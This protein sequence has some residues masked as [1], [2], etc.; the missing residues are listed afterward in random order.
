MCILHARAQP[1]HLRSIKRELANL[2]DL[3]HPNICALYGVEATPGW[4]HL[5]II[6]EA[7]LG[8]GDE[9]WPLSKALRDSGGRLAEATARSVFAQLLSGLAFAHS[10]L[11][12]HR[13]LNPEHVHVARAAAFGSDGFTVKLTNFTA[14]KTVLEPAAPTL[15]GTVAMFRA[16]EVTL[17]E[18]SPAGTELTPAQT[19]A[20]DVWAAGAILMCMLAG[21]AAIS[22]WYVSDNKA[23]DYTTLV[24]AGGSAPF[25]HRCVGRLPDASPGAREAA[26]A[27]FTET[28]EARPSAAD[29]LTKSAWVAA[30]RYVPGPMPPALLTQSKAQLHEFV[31]AVVAAAAAMA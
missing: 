1:R 25:W 17:A 21:E 26:A 5:A 4:T 15:L 7:S 14:S 16:P 23:I 24:Q 6:M 28:P 18:F 12:A 10:K 8:P 13:D 9:Q 19:L 30:E 27:M 22:G 29:M 2:V 20:T 31:D 3:Q 11:C